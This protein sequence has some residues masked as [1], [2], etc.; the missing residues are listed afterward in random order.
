MF[1]VTVTLW[2]Y[3]VE[4]EL[5]HLVLAVEKEKYRGKKGTEKRKKMKKRKVLF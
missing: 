4:T 5:P 1:V 3:L 2:L